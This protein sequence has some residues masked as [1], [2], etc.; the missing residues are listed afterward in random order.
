MSAQI[1]D[2]NLRFNADSAKFEKDVESVKK[3]LRGYATDANAANDSNANFSRGLK[4]STA[5]L[6]SMGAGVA[7]T[8]T[9]I[10][11][12][13]AAIAA[14]SV[15][16]TRQ[17]AEQARQIEKQAVVAQ[18]SVEQIQSLTYAA[19]QFGIE[20]DKMS[21]I[22][23]DTND[24][25]GDFSETGGGEF[26]DFIENI[27]PK[28]GLTIEKLQQM[29]GPDALIAV[30]SALDAANVP[31]KSQIFYLESIA[32]EASALIPLLENN[33]QKL[34]AL[35][36]RYD[37]LNVAMSQ[38]DIDRFKQ[39]DQ[40]ITDIEL[41]LERSFGNLSRQVTH[42]LLP[43]MDSVSSYTLMMAKGVE[44]YA[45]QV[46]AL[47]V[48]SA[49]LNT[50]SGTSL[51]EKH[52]EIFGEYVELKS[53][54]DKY[55]GVSYDDL[56]AINPFG[57]SKNEWF[58]LQR[59]YAMK[60]DELK[61]LN[62]EIVKQQK[63]AAGWFDFEDEI[64]P[65]VPPTDGSGGGDGG[66]AAAAARKLEAEQ[67][68]SATR[69]AALDN[70][71]ADERTKLQ[72]AH[73]QRLSDIDGMV[74][75][76]EEIKRRGFESMAALRQEYKDLEDE[77]YLQ[78]QEEFQA[79][80]DQQ[81]QA[82]LDAFARKEEE[83]TRKL[84]REAKQRA[85]IEKRID[86]QVLAMKYNLASQTLGL[87]AETAKEGTFIQKAAFMAQKAMA[88][89]QVFQQGEVAAM[90]ALAPPPIGL[91]PTA[92][93]G[94]AAVIRAMAAVSAGMIF[95]QALSGMAHSGIDVVPTEGTWLLDK[96][97]RVYTNDSARRIDQM[98]N[99]MMNMNQTRFAVNDPVNRQN[100]QGM[101]NMFK[102]ENHFNES[103]AGEENWQQY[104]E[105]VNAIVYETLEKEMRPGGKLWRG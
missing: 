35:T 23:K 105:A 50:I 92:G 74:L 58:N 34:H 16:M 66:A 81:I 47:G 36:S 89:M 3:M 61:A 76:E 28:V 102:F 26:A 67:K 9:L 71:Y 15:A 20:G 14:A 59:D 46:K 48:Y 70:Q 85:D 100:N 51:K 96:G 73:E 62:D 94:Q 29:S 68:A 32:D 24:K 11:G 90:A 22:L 93:Q 79:R 49:T 95:G 17:Q 42:A 55:K 65:P 103:S 40:E 27:A 41:K 44:E 31:M 101:A 10:V 33:G 19:Q 75:S 25:L 87:I 60:K 18:V 84:D 38:F 57:L 77:F 8:S 86:Q 37:N 1:A 69:L 97:E 43:T 91:G 5:D 54:L 63:D 88:A 78:Q 56:P 83:K 53:E 104:G 6:A 4:V 30:K 21:D 64:K 45:K 99:M 13:T 12:A 2:F 80:Q 52:R 39:M 7:A 72:L 98:Y 82:E